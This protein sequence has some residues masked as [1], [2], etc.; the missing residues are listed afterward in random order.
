MNAALAPKSA[1]TCWIALPTP[2][3]IEPDALVARLKADHDLPGLTIEADSRLGGEEGTAADAVAD[4]TVLL[5]FGDA[6]LALA[7]VADPLPADALD[8][9]LNL[10]REWPKA[11]EAFS[12]M[13][14]MIMVTNFT[15]AADFSEAVYTAALVTLT[16]A[17]LTAMAPA[18]ALYWV[19][20]ETV[21][22]PS[23]FR[24]R[25]QVLPGGARPMDLWTQFALLSDRDT[26]GR[27]TTTAI[28]FGLLPFVGREVEIRPSTEPK[29]EVARRL[30]GIMEYL[31]TQGPVL[32]DGDTLGISPTERLRVRTAESDLRAGLPIY[33][34]TIEKLA[35]A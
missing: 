2:F 34:L 1:L 20:A 24:E 33:A 35:P 26:A 14:S 3:R 6:E 16:A 30:L 23:V 12:Q 32:D 8:L 21:T 22:A 9:A 28:S 18:L 17:S 7:C 19:P 11:R 27:E 5:N 25:S 10:N 15:A 4:Q 13:R 31:L 29:P